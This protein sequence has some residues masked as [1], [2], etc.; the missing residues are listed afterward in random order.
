MNFDALISLVGDMEWFD[1]ATL[2]QLS[3]ERRTTISNQL[4]RLGKAGRIVPLRR[5]MYALAPRYRR[6][7]IQ[8]AALANALCR[9]SYLSCEWALSFHGVIPESVPV[10]TSVTS[11][12]PQRFCNDL[13]EFSYR[14]VKRELFFGYQPVQLSGRSVLVASP[15][16]ALLDLFHLSRG[17]W[18]AAR[19][20]EM[21]FSSA[22]GVDT[23]LLE[24]TAVRVGGPRLL[25][26]AALWS[27]I[28]HE[29][30]EGEV[31]L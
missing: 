9:P 3:D 8:P 4:F 20:E 1:L 18:T 2:V 31:A 25:R 12:P 7:P 15:E 14:N 30:G 21:R 29:A 19:M 24:E 26:A 27:K 13:G 23:A 6:V 10:F 28:V 5:G 22:A 11:R 16:K 17:E